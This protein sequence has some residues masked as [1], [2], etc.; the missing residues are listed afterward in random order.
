K[1]D[2]DSFVGVRARALKMLSD[3][4]ARPTLVRFFRD[5]MGIARLDQIDK[6]PDLFPNFTPTIGVSMRTEI[7]MMFAATVFD[8]GGDFRDL[9][10]TRSTFV[11]G[12]LAKVYGIKGPNGP[13]FLR[14]TLPDDGKRAG[15]LTTA[16]FLA[17]NAH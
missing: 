7:E 13:D 14:V 8:A 6:S 2:L 1:G 15:L 11:N 16:G 12:E 4:R 9:F 3:P 5:F 17:M 10:T